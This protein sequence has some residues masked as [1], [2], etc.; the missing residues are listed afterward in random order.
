MEKIC[1]DALTHIWRTKLKL[2]DYKKELLREAF[3]VI[4]DKSG[5]VDTYAYI[6]RE[7]L[8]GTIDLLGLETQSIF[9][10]ICNIGTSL[11]KELY[12]QK[13]GV[14]TDILL[15]SWV[16]VVRGKNPRQ[17]AYTKGG[18]ERYHKHTDINE[19][20]GMFKPEYTFVYYIQM[21][22]VMDN[23]DGVLYFL[24]EN[25]VEYQ[26]R[27]EEDNLIIMEGNV[28]HF[29]NNA[30]NATLDRYVLAGNIGFDYIKKKKTL[31]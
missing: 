29:P 24:G 20:L 16:N 3:E 1:Y 5:V 10:K 11:C 4:A 21:P 19:K 12:S 15:S 8:D 23:D 26:I 14:Y 25:N 28:P 2:S 30:P 7:V 9:Q 13:G 18:N 31:L 6:N 27:P 17:P 22:D